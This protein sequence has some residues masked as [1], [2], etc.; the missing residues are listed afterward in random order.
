[1]K[2]LNKGKLLLALH[3]TRLNAYMINPDNAIYEKSQVPKDIRFLMDF[4]QYKNDCL[5]VCS[6]IKDNEKEKID[7]IILPFGN[8]ITP[9]VTITAWWYNIPII[10]LKS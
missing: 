2:A 3:P 9:L 8:S 1:M 7:M 6:R 5:E 4:N 10:L